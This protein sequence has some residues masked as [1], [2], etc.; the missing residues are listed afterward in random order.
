[1]RYFAL[2]L[3][4]ILF[5]NF[6][7]IFAGDGKVNFSGEWTLNKDKSD[8]GDSGGRRRGRAATKLIIEQ[9]DNKLVV[10]FFRQ[11][12]DG[13]EVSRKLTFTLDGKKNKNDMNF[14]DQVSTAEWSD[15]G[16]TLTIES[17]MTM[18]RG[19]REF[20][21]ESTA[22]WSLVDDTLTIDSARTTPRGERKS[23]AVYN[24]TDKKK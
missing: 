4:A 17:K 8:L 12:R 5:L 2:F 20:T 10:E 24:K 13:E 16:K 3:C 19:D 22:N 23:K 18:S 1:M 9:E 15:D 6:T 11:N 7:I 14:G 21:I